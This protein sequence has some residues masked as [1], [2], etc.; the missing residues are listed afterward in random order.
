[1]TDQT[2]QDIHH[3]YEEAHRKS[4]SIVGIIKTLMNSLSQ[5]D[6]SILPAEDIPSF[7]AFLDGLNACYHYRE[8]T[9]EITVMVT[10]LAI[11]LLAIVEW[12]SSLQ[13]FIGS[14]EWV[15]PPQKRRF[16]VDVFAGRKSL[17]SDLTKILTKSIN[18]PDVSAVSSDFFGLCVVLINDRDFK[19]PRYAIRLISR[20]VNKV[21]SG[22]DRAM[23]NDFIS[24]FT[25][26]GSS[27][28]LPAINV[29]MS[30]PL[31][32]DHVEE[33]DKENG[34]HSI[35]VDHTVKS[36]ATYASL[37]GVPFEIQYQSYP[38]YLEA[39]LGKAAH[40]T[41]KNAIDKRI[42]N[43]FCLADYSQSNIPGLRNDLDIDG[44]KKV[45]DERKHVAMRRSQMYD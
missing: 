30:I 36:F 41:Y 22:Q 45:N 28:S 25:E 13:E 19:D 8:N 9:S 3:A 11:T 35:H 14:I 33:F 24:W 27:L 6:S 10:Y 21:L 32:I 39:K 7:N 37:K 26:K 34:Y 29:I 12:L 31:S 17:E 16:Y 2:L 1:M 42:A 38:D 23:R 40:R 20:T 15:C 18:N 5:E 43:V 4:S 44:I